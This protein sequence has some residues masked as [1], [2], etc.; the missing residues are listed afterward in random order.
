PM[1][2]SFSSRAVMAVTLFI[3]TSISAPV[4][5]QSVQTDKTTYEVGERVIATFSGCP[6]RG[7]DWVG[8]Y[9]ASQAQ[10]QGSTYWRYCQGGQTPAS[11]G[12][13]SGSLTFLPFSLPPGDWQARLFFNDSYT[14][15]SVANFSIV[16]RA[17]SPTPPPAGD[18]TVMS[19]NIW[20]SGTN[21]P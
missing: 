8:I 1:F 2:A 3:A 9:P 12:P 19:L 4:R 7:T 17:A 15:R 6:G 20:V 18:L 5:A 16:S 21:V 13:A 14:L 10:N 11:S